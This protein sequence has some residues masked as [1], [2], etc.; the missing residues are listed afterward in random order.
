MNIEELMKF[1]SSLST[2]E[3]ES[4]LDNLK[5]LVFDDKNIYEAKTEEYKRCNCPKCTSESIIKYGFNKSH[6]QRYQCKKCS[7]IFSDSTGS[8][9]YRLQH[10]SK[11]YEYIELIFDGN[12]YSVRKMGELLEINHKTAF[13]WRHKLLYAINQKIEMLHGIVEIDDLHFGFSQKGR[14]G[15]ISPRKRGK[16]NKKRG[17]NSEYVKVL[18]TMDREGNML[19]D[20]IRIGRLQAIDIECS[21]GSIL[22]SQLNILTSDKH[23]SIKSFAKKHDIRHETFKADKHVRSR[24]YHVNT[25]NERARRFTHRIIHG[26]KGVSTKYLNNYCNWFKLLEYLKY[27]LL[28]FFYESFKSHGTHELFQNR[29]NNYQQFLTQLSSI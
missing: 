8:A 4:V 28:D 19:M 1:I 5:Q 12:Y 15:L 18:T 9:I 10:K 24:V 16:E 25:I 17:D 21:V 11:W 26:F 3:K 13:E 6:E 7:T 14:K 22:N 20:V 29:E 27:G 2:L 23:P